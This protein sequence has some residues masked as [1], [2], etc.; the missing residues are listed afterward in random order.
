MA[1]TRVK[2]IGEPMKKRTLEEISKMFSLES[3]T[4]PK[5]N[6]HLV[7]HGDRLLVRALAAASETKDGFAITERMAK[8]QERIN[9]MCEV[10]AIGDEVEFFN[11][12]DIVLTLQYSGRPLYIPE[13]RD[14]NLHVI[15]QADIFCTVFSNSKKKVRKI[16]KD[17]AH[18]LGGK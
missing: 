7:W 17:K 10:L 2:T 11:V 4:N 14:L 16:K 13:L 9:N 12:G 1:R 6:P 8:Q 15:S 18:D 5:I 3:L